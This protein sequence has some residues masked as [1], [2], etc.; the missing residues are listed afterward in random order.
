MSGSIC[1]GLCSRPSWARWALTSL[2]II[3]RSGKLF[4]WGVD[5]G[6]F[7]TVLGAVAPPLIN[8][9]FGSKKKAKAQGVD[10]VKL[11]RDAEAAGFNPL[12]ALL[13]GGGQ[14]YQR[15]FNPELS[16]GSFIAEAVARGAETYFNTVSQR[17]AQAEAIKADH[18]AR[19]QR[20]AL[21]DART[22][23]GGFGYDLSAQRPFV[24]AVVRAAPPLP[25]SGRVSQTVAQSAPARP[26]RNPL[27]RQ[28]F[29]PVRMPNGDRGRLDSSIA[30]RLDIRPWD[31]VSVGDTEELVGDLAGGASAVSFANSISETATG[32]PLYNPFSLRIYGPAGV[33]YSPPPMADK[34]AK[35]KRQPGSRR[36]YPGWMNDFLGGN[37]PQ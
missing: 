16:S 37:Y 17:D 22:P 6:L 23:T 10:Y 8:G 34:K 36:A 9:I 26:P 2:P 13:A 1:L 18:D 7:A 35:R 24:P 14:G 15:E 29:I 5:M 4:A 32:E 21:R 28:A 19:N 12:T 27:D 31:T 3:L 33:K 30:R 20:A 11:R 25:P